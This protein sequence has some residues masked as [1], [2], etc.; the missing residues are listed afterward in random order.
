[1][2]VTFG[3]EGSRTTEYRFDPR[4]VI[5]QP[6]LNG[7]HE[8]PEIETLIADMLSKPDGKTIKGQT[9]PVIIR[10]DGDKPVLV[11]GHRRLRA[12]LEINRRK[13]TPE[14]MQLR[15]SYMQLSEVEALA[16]AVTENR[17]RCGVTPLDEAYNIKQFIRLGKDYEWIA[18]RGGFFPLLRDTNRTD[19]GN[20]AKELKKAIAW[21]KKREKLLGLT[22]EAQKALSDGKLKPTAAE[23]LADLEAS[24]QRDLLKKGTPTDAEIRE[25]Q[26][27]VTKLTPKQVREEIDTALSEWSTAKGVPKELLDWLEQLKSRI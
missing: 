19:N 5:V 10:K 20:Y 22:E 7:R 14:P 2:A 6:E 9:T 8:L 25:A 23:H 27:K 17:E 12:V 11:A 16:V 21:I 24:K 15:C 18:T 13:L 3:V 4:A 26:G 1:M